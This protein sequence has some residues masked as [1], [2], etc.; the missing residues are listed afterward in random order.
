MEYFNQVYSFIGSVEDDKIQYVAPGPYSKSK[1][2][3]ED[4]NRS[5]DDLD[6]ND[7][8]ES[9]KQPDSSDKN[10]PTQ[11]ATHATTSSMANKSSLFLNE[12]NKPSN[13]IKTV[14]F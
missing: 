6:I 11:L 14:N 1:T 2:H 7:K 8:I 10:N 5:I 4:L 3:I 12:K 13:K 9:S